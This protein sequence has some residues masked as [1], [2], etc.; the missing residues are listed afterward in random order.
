MEEILTKI[1]IPKQLYSDQEGAFNNIEFIRLMKNI[2]L[3]RLWLLM[4]L[5]PLKDLT[6]R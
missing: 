1:G 5:T 4:V 6:E 2:R 3:N